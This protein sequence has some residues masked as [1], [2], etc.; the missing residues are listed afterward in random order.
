MIRLML[1]NPELQKA[2]LEKFLHNFI[3]AGKLFMLVH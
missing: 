3:H 1:A 2:D